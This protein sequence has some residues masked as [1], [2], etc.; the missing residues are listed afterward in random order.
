LTSLAGQ[1]LVAMPQMQDERFARTVIYVCMHN[2]GGAM[3]LVVNKLID[4]LTLT[5]LLDQLGIDAAG[6]RGETTVHFGGPVEAHHGFVLHSA[7]YVEDCTLVVEGGMALTASM[8]I[9]RAIGAGKGPRRSMLALGYAGWGPGQLDTELQANGW[10]H[11]AADEAIVFDGDLSG[12]WH[13]ALKKLG[14]SPAA[15]S[16]AAGHA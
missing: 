3:G 13:R 6:L 10:L 12:T 2:E 9:L 15:L 5:E 7:D 8:D 16:S 4:S 14:I 1:L 11:V